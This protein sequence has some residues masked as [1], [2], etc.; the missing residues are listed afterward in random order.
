MSSAFY[1]GLRDVADDL[2]STFGE[3][4][5][6]L[7][8][9]TTY[10]DPN[11]PWEGPAA[12]TDPTAQSVPADAVWLDLSNDP[13][14]TTGAGIGRGSTTVEEHRARVLVRAVAALTEELGTDWV[15]MRGAREYSI[16]AV[17][18]QNPGGTLIYYEVIVRV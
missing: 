2:I 1:E 5:T 18:P 10:A 4:I 17:R 6:L 14:T 13:F 3:V 12:D 15:I 9:P 7:R 16:T 11:A 8:E